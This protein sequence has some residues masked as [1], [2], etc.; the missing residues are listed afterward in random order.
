MRIG[1]RSATSRTA[2][3]ALGLGLAASTLVFAQNAE[4]QTYEVTVTNITKGQTF[5]PILALTHASNVSV[6]ELGEEASAELETLAEAGGIDDLRNALETS[7]QNV[8]DTGTN[9]AMLTPGQTTTIEIS[10]DRGARRVSVLAM[11]IPTNDTFFAVNNM[12]APGRVGVTRS[13]LALAYDAGTEEN[14]QNCANIP[15]PRCNGQGLSAASESDEGFIHISNGFHELGSEDGDENEILGP[16][17]Y[18]WR[19]PVAKVSIRRLN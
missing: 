4:A 8:P 12:R 6:F 10:G 17:T 15:G 13:T 18:D 5:T 19:N 7:G 2:T 9:G 16:F 11:L 14:D 1:T 3:L